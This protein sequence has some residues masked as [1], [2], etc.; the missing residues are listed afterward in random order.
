VFR[1]GLGDSPEVEAL[2]LGADADA[3]V[4]LIVLSQ[5]SV[6]RAPVAVMP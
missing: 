4:T 6:R 5:D 3:F 2:K 1:S